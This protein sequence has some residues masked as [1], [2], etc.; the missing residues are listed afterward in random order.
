[1]HAQ[2]G[3]PAQ[4]MEV[5]SHGL[6]QSLEQSEPHL[7][8]KPYCIGYIGSLVEHKG[9][10]VLLEALARVPDGDL[11][12]RI[13]GAMDDSAYVAR[14]RKLAEGDQR[15]KFM[16]TFEPSNMLNVIKTMDVLA[17]PSLWYENEPLVIKS[18]LQAGIPVLCNDIGSLSGMVDHGRTG[19]LVPF[20]DPDGWVN[21]IRNIPAQLPDLHMQ[22]VRMKTMQENANE[23][24]LIYSEAIR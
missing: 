16:G 7:P 11:H 3:I 18:A 12:C 10:H 9:V 13:Y 24:L 22:P 4:R 15:V 8:V 23:M 17:V 2:N 1:M 6:E 19:W 14:L 20:G 5:V 21:A